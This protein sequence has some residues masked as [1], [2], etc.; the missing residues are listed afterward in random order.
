MG[1]DIHGYKVSDPNHANGLAYL[2]RG[3][4][5]QS[6]SALYRALDAEDLDGFYSGRG[7]RTFTVE[8]LRAALA[9]LPQD[10][11]HD[12]ERFFLETCI[13]NSDGEAVEITF[14]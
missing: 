6:V 10:D 8:Q 12:R 5:S 9:R 2:R 4:L 13:N 1:H 11:N 7:K 3:A 14:Y